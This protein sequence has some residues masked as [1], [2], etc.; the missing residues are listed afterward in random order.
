MRLFCQ[1][2]GGVRDVSHFCIIGWGDSVRVGD[3][4]AGFSPSCSIQKVRVH[5]GPRHDPLHPTEEGLFHFSHGTGRTDS[6]GLGRPDSVAVGGLAEAQ[7]V[8]LRHPST[9]RFAS[10]HDSVLV[11]HSVSQLWWND[12]LCPLRPWSV[13][14]C[15]A[16]ER[17]LNP[18]R[19]CVCGR[20]SV[21][22]GECLAASVSRCLRH[23]EDAS[24]RFT[25][26]QLCGWGS[27]DRTIDGVV[28]VRVF[29][30]GRFLSC[31]P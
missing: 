9:A 18:A 15:T 8:G 26:A 27:V 11:W 2:I 23:R 24:R 1:T 19:W 31:G 25:V 3:V 7:L 20:R 22:C 4:V 21:E 28:A 16:C 30:A 6:G 10:L 13:G 17:S 29:L 14:E 5:H 12:G